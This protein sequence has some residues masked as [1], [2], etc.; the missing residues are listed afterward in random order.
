[1]IENGSQVYN[2]LLNGRR[3]TPIPMVQNF[4]LSWTSRLNVNDISVTYNL[5]EV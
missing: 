3:L 5:F 2:S 4:V 1:M